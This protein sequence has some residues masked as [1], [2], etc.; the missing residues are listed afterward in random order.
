MSRESSKYKRACYICDGSGKIWPDPNQTI[1][2]P[3][4]NVC[5]RC[6]GTLLV[7]GLTVGEL[8]MLLVGV[9]D[10]APVFIKPAEIKFP[11]TVEMDN[12]PHEWNYSI[13]GFP[14]DE[15]T[16]VA[17]VEVKPKKSAGTCGDTPLKDRTISVR[18]HP[19]REAF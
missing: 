15:L 5:W 10:E 7:D 6:K 9:P 1:L 12:V 19:I 3:D 13:K 4:Q 11:I 2:P 16:E 18:L 14:D 8:K 17:S